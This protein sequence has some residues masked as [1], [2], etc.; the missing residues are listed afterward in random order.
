M[1]TLWIDTDLQP[2]FS[3]T[4]VHISFRNHTQ[5]KKNP[6]LTNGVI[7]N[8]MY[9]SS[10]DYHPNDKTRN[11][12]SKLPDDESF[13]ITLCCSFLSDTFPFLALTPY[14]D[15]C[16][17]YTLPKKIIFCFVSVRN[18]SNFANWW[19]GF[20]DFAYMRII[21]GGFLEMWQELREFHVP[22]LRFLENLNVKSWHF[23]G[24]W[25]EYTYWG[26]FIYV[27]LSEKVVGIRLLMSFGSWVFDWWVIRM[28]FCLVE[29]VGVK[30]D[31]LFE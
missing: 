29:D 16:R 11:G 31:T 8:S 7:N 24:L 17:F 9:P 22:L 13:L 26:K 15:K 6:I 5:K 19:N 20:V 25:I 18:S 10:S 12:K 23:G 30:F 4:H 1:V 14:H 2:T 27:V 28:G 21:R 3:H